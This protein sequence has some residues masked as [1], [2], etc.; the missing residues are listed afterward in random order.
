VLAPPNRAR[1]GVS[2]FSNVAG[3]TAARTIQAGS[4]ALQSYL[5]CQVRA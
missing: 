2:G 5:S 1:A 3:D 4:Q